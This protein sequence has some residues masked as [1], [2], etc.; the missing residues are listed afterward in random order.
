MKYGVF[1]NWHGSWSVVLA[2]GE[3]FGSFACS[4]DAHRVARLNRL[5]FDESIRLAEMIK[6]SRE[7]VKVIYDALSR[8]GNFANRSF[9][10]IDVLEKCKVILGKENQ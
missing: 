3:T 5:E 2:S 1:Q 10:E 6:F 8:L 7:D 4:A 9:L